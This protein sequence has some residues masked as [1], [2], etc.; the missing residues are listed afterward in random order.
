MARLP[1]MF[2][3]FLPIMSIS[4]TV[5]FLPSIHSAHAQKYDHQALTPHPLAQEPAIRPH[6]SKSLAA[7]LA[8]DDGA[9]MG[10]TSPVDLGE[11]DAMKGRTLLLMVAVLYGTLNVTLRL[12][13]Q[14]PADIVPSAAALS[15]ARG[16]FATVGFLPLMAL[17][18]R[19]AEPPSSE[20]SPLAADSSTETPSTGSFLLAGFELAVWNMLAQGLLSV[21]LLSTTSARAAF[22]TQT[23]VVLTPLISSLFG[24]KIRPTVWGACGLALAGLTVLAGGGASTTGSL[25]FDLGSFNTG[26]CLVLGGALSWSLYL[27]RVSKIGSKFD[28]VRLQFTK[29]TMLAVLYSG[30]LAVGVTTSA[31]AGTL[32]SSFEWLLNGTALAVLAYSAWGP[33]TIADVLQQ[34]G[35]KH[36]SAS[37]ANI[38]LSL[39]PISA[40]LCAWLLLGE[41]TSPSEMVGGGIILAAALIATV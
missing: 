9:P 29:S 2:V 12:I 20:I 19:Q 27:F 28:D 8:D 10:E 21:G 17:Q 30:W 23:S 26:D 33:G 18:P 6:R 1:R 36:V 37:E 11:S 40:A 38:I 34:Q 22:L 41:V 39:E 31:A 4:S 13:Y 25:G 35:Q 7:I 15:T 5:A 3:W 24:D 16:W 14:L 32:T